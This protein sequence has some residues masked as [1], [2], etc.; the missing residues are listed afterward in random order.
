MV[1]KNLTQ[2]LMAIGILY[3]RDQKDEQRM[4]D[5]PEDKKFNSLQ[6]TEHRRRKFD[7][8]NYCVTGLLSRCSAGTV[9][10]EQNKCKFSEKSTISHRCMYYIE[11][12][13]GHCDCVEAQ[14]EMRMKD[15]PKK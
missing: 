9:W 4:S 8:I 2:D 12:I 5:A 7:C 1:R 6:Q 10:D 3:G 14:S 13:D 15:D 11:A